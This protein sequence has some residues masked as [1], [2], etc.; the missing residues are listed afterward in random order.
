MSKETIGVVLASHSKSLVMGVM[1][2]LNAVGVDVSITYAGG[3]PVGDLGSD[4]NA[5]TEAIE[6][7]PKDTLLAFY[8]LGSAK[9]NLEMA[10]EMSD[11]DVRLISTAFVEGAYTATA[12]LQAD[13]SIEEIEKQLE[14]VTIKK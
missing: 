8:D 7:N 2:L 5:V 10:A 1:E 9:M 12:L 4:Y 14:D 3:L 6:S 13:A 11:K